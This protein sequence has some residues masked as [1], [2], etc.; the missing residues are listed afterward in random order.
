[1]W[2]AHEM[3]FG[4]GLAVVAGFLLTAVPNWTG[5]P[6]VHGRGLGG[7]FGLWCA[8]RV[9]FASAW[10][11]PLA[12]FTTALFNLALFVIAARPIVRARQWRQ[13]GILS[14]LA[15]LGLA[16]ALFFLGQFGALDNG[17]RFGVYLGLY[18]LVAL[19][20][21]LLR[22]L[23]PFFTERGVGYAVS[24]RNSVW[25]D[26][27]SLVTMLAFAVLATFTEARLFTAL[28]ALAASSVHLARLRGWYTH[29]IWRRPLLWSLHVAYALFALAFAVHAL[30][31]YY[32][33]PPSAAVHCFALGGI[34]MLTVSMM[35]RVSLGHTGRDVHRP[36]AG[37]SII[38]AW[39]MGAFA[40]RQASLWVWPAA[41]S[42]LV[43]AAALAWCGALMLVAQLLVPMLAAPRAQE[44]R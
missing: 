9:A 27:A 12:A 20:L 28:V 3:V 25:L 23:I 44:S 11:S 1:M 4:Y 36:P 2:H 42:A 33:A 15:L 6:T 13:L 40:L 18:V 39:L 22:R 32:L 29:G 31:L 21:T 35:L 37:T 24:L 19:A 14:K 7:L 10:P 38:F 8:T 16:D 5:L 17:A 41:Y 43:V 34:G 26:R 30:A